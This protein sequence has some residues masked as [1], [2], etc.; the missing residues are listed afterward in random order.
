MSAPTQ[1][2]V[3][4]ECQA[5]GCSSVLQASAAR[6]AGFPTAVGSNEDVCACNPGVVLLQVAVPSTHRQGDGEVLVRCGRCHK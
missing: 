1:T 2:Q 3:L 6:L 4:V 5:A